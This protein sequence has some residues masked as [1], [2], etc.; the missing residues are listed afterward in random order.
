MTARKST[1]Q[2]AERSAQAPARDI[3]IGNDG[4]QNPRCLSP[5]PLDQDVPPE[6][7]HDT[8]ERSTL[9]KARRNNT[10]SRTDAY[11]LVI[12]S[13]HGKETI[14]FLTN[15]SW[16]DDVALHLVQRRRKLVVI[17]TNIRPNDNRGPGHIILR[18]KKRKRRKLATQSSGSTV[19]NTSSAHQ[20]ISGRIFVRL[21]T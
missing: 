5:T 4:R 18:P 12:I 1:N 10:V 13:S 6:F 21:I 7:S 8:H 16:I 9:P 17:S 15:W 20:A 3:T 19:G 11:I 14:A 2:T